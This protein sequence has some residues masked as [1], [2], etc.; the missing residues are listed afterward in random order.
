MLEMTTELQRHVEH[1]RM[2]VEL[3]QT[4]A[5]SSS[6]VEATSLEEL[7]EDALRISA[8]ALGRHGI[9]LERQ[10]VPL[11]RLMLDK[12]KLLQILLN[13]L[14]NAKYAL[15]H[16]PPGQRLLRVNVS[17]P[18][19]DRVCVQ[20]SDNGMGIAPELLTKIF[21]HGFTTRKEGDRIE[22]VLAQ[23]QQRD[24]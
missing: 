15:N 6:L 20:V 24:G 22:E 21:Q 14:S 8:A 10:L 17:R 7:L 3:Q 23:A 16:Q 5:T 11:P 4:Y 12:H 9:T 2:I 13:L 18:A 19:E 1:I